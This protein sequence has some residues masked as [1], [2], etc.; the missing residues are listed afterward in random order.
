MR[1]TLPQLACTRGLWEGTER[2]HAC[3]PYTSHM[4]LCDL[5]KKMQSSKETEITGIE[6]QNL[7]YLR[8][9]QKL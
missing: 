6:D 9:L 3:R 7:Y 2:V 5:E 1:L 4:Y 8:L